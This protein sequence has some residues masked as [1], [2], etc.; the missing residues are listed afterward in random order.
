M[1]SLVVPIFPVNADYLKY[2]AYQ[3]EQQYLCGLLPNHLQQ[4]VGYLPQLV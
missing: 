3:W 4:A 2:A 1:K